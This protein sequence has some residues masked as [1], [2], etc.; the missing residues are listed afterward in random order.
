MGHPAIFSG[1]CA[2]PARLSIFIRVDS[3]HSRA[4]SQTAEDCRYHNGIASCE[5]WNQSRGS[6]AE[7]AGSGV[8]RLREV[9]ARAGWPSVLS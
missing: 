5:T 4:C 6:W 1:I 2:V 3:R 9:L 7:A 8:R